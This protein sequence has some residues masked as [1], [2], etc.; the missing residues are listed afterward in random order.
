MKLSFSGILE[1]DMKMVL[2]AFQEKYPQSFE[3]ELTQALQDMIQERDQYEIKGANLTPEEKQDYINYKY[4]IEVFVE[5]FKRLWDD[6]T[7]DEYD[8]C[9]VPGERSSD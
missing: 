5:I 6:P 2:T 1:E 3:S 4:D 9:P 8:I 7:I